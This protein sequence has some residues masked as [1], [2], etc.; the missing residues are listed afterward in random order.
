[1]VITFWEEEGDKAIGLVL[2]R[3]NLEQIQRNRF[4]IFQT[5]RVRRGGLMVGGRFLEGA[6]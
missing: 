3:V 2:L 1:M 5:K 4:Y 6:P